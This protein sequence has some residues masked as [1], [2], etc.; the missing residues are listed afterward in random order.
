MRKDVLVELI[1]LLYQFDADYQSDSHY[2]TKE[3]VGFLNAR[4]GPEATPMRKIEGEEQPQIQ[5][6][7]QESQSDAAILITF[8]FRYARGYVKKALQESAIQTT[9]EFAFLITLMTHDS[10]TKTE[11]INTQV[12]EKTSGVEVIKR[13]LSQKMIRE[14]ADDHDKRSVRVAITPKG[15]KELEQV[16]PAMAKVS[17]IVVGNLSQPEIN[18]LTYLLKKLDFF[19]HDIFMHKKALGLDQLLNEMVTT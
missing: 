7:R 1:D 4:V 17:R 13:L 2:T 18:T 3:F 10:L 6:I 14:F 12:M 9:D 8:M 11:L 19:H 16:L 5:T 15:K